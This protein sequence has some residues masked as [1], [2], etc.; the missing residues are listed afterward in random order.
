MLLVD[1]T[2]DGYCRFAD[3][4]A[5]VRNA[6]TLG[7]RATLSRVE[8]ASHFFGLY[9]R[10]GQQQMRTAIGDA[11]QQWGWDR[12]GRNSVR[13]GSWTIVPDASL[14]AGDVSRRERTSIATGF[15]RLS[16]GR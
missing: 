2:Q 1:A 7:V 13:E 12:R 11:L 15:G 9:N 6:Q 16:T 3:A 4:E 14:P 10:R 5:F 8:G